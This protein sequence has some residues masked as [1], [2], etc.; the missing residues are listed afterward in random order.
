MIR[1][2]MAVGLGVLLCLVGG[3]AILDRLIP[4]PLE[5]Y[6]T[7][8]PTALTPQH[9]VDPEDGAVVY[10]IEGLQV[11]ARLMSDKELND[12]EP[13]K[14]YRENATNPFTYGIWK[15]P[16]KRYTPVRFTVFHIAVYNYP[17]AKVELDPAQ[18]VLE[19]DRGGKYTYYDI[20]ESDAPNSFEKYYK[21]VSGQSGNEEFWYEERMGL[22]RSRLY[23][24]GEP[25]FKGDHYDGMLVFEPLHKDVKHIRLVIKDFVLRF[26]SYG[27]P[28]DTQDVYF[29]FDTDQGVRQVSKG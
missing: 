9:S 10:D 29:E 5:Y 27:N 6:V 11:R 21:S 8:T 15:D 14:S 24:R 18:A 12:L 1:T 7:A 13:D 22:V 28:L 2:S 4:R 16:V 19:T 25:V 3:C 23:R 17:F 26:D 20:R